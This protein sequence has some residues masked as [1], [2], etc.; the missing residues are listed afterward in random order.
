MK[1]L[2]VFIVIFVVFLMFIVL[3]LNNKCDISLGFKTFSDI[4]VFISSLFSFIL[5]MLFAVPMIFS[6]GKKK[7]KPSGSESS[8]LPPSGGKKKF[9]GKKGSSAGKKPSESGS[10]NGKE[11]SSYGID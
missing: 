7:I 9:L 6:L 8:N 2:I 5:G 1:R 4:P 3:N 11:D 10:D